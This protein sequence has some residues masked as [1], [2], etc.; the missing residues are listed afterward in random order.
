MRYLSLREI[1]EL[2]D[3]LVDQLLTPRAARACLTA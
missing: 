2:N 3:A 1:L